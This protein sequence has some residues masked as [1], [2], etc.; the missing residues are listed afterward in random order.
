M[1]PAPNTDFHYEVKF[2]ST[3]SQ[4]YQMQGILLENTA[5]DYFYVEY[6]HDGT[7]L[8]LFASTIRNGTS[9]KRANLPL[10]LDGDLYLQVRRRNDTWRIYYGTDGQ[11]WT[12]AA[13]FKYIMP[14]NKAGV[15]AGSD[16]RKAGGQPGFT[17]VVDY[18]FNLKAP[19]LDEDAE[20]P[21]I[22]L[23]V[24]GEG[25]VQKTPNKPIYECGESVSLLAK[26]AKDWTFDGWSGGL[27]G[28]NPQRTVIFTGPLNATATFSKGI[29]VLKVLLPMVIR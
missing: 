8:R 23:S 11:N 22:N 10:T 6:L 27:T 21:V 29:P 24:V 26:P 14:V 20:P 5:D 12:Q 19:I 3:P 7:T 18:F 9:W 25:S 17:A 13:S 1:Q 16:S 28:S 15:F 2:E 4:Q